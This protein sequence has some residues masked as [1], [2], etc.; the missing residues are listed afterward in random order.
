M[1]NTAQRLLVERSDRSAVNALRAIVTSGSVPVAK[2]HALGT[3]DALQS[4]DDETLRRALGDADAQA[5]TAAIDWAAPRLAV[6]QM[7]REALLGIAKSNRSR[8]VRFRLAIALAN[9]EGPE[10]IATM[11]ELANDAAGRFARRR[12]HHRQFGFGNRPILDALVDKNDTWRG[13]PSAAQLRLLSQL[14]SRAASTDDAA[15]AACLAIIG[16]STSQ[17]TAPGD[18]AIL[19]GIAQGLGDRGKSLRQMLAEPKSTI[20]S[21]GEALGHVDCQRANSGRARRRADRISI[22]RGRG[23]GGGGFRRRRDLARTARR[24]ASAGIAI[25]GRSRLGQADPATAAKMFADWDVRHHRHATGTGRRGTWFA[26]GTHGA[27]SMRSRT[28]RFKA[29]A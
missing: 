27:V 19:V 24:A 3:L 14:A 21:H 13:T 2:A 23:A 28:T 6:S 7:L 10:K 1:R 8:E 9:V 5:C 25:G 26:C 11:V 16:S 15:L 17:Q 4:L 22:D 20:T 29:R 12:G 18:L